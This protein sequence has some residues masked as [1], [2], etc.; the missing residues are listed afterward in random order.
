MG[1]SIAKPNNIG[2]STQPTFLF[3]VEAFSNAA[4]LGHWKVDMF[5][6]LSDEDTRV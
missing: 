3:G 1:V 4:Q 2:R 6:V 5:Q